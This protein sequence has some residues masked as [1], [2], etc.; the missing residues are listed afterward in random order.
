MPLLINLHFFYKFMENEIHNIKQ[1]QKEHVSIYG[2][3]TSF[4]IQ[5]AGWQICRG[6]KAARLCPLEQ[7]QLAWF[8]LLVIRRHNYMINI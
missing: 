1:V 5:Y 4:I 6:P 3:K 8:L 2:R 7:R